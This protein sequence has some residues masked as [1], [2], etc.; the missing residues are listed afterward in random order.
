[1]HRLPTWL[2]GIPIDTLDFDSTLQRIVEW[3]ARDGPPRYVATS[4]VDFLV[5][6][7]AWTS[8]S[9][10]HPELLTIL[11]EAALNTAD[12]MPLVWASR[13]L[14]GRVSERVSGSDLVPALGE[15]AAG[16]QLPLFLLG[17]R[18]EA[19]REAAERLQTRSPGLLIAG[20]ASPFVHVEGKAL[21]HEEKTDRELCESINQSGARILLVGFGNP[22]QEVWFRRNAE[23]LKVPVV[24]GVGGTFNFLAGHVARAPAWMQRS[25]VEWLHRLWSEPR[26]LW[27]RYA[28]GLTKLAVILAPAI[29]AHTLLRWGTEVRSGLDPVPILHRG[30][31]TLRIIR[32]PPAL[33]DATA[34]EL[35]DLGRTDPDQPLL[36]DLA[37]CRF[38]DAHGLGVLWTIHTASAGNDRPLWFLEP[39]RRFRLLLQTHRAWATFAPR[40]CASLE[41]AV[42]RVNERLRGKGLFVAVEG[43]RE[44]VVL[45]LFG[46]M[47]TEETARLDKPALLQA[48]A[49]H[50]TMLDL[51]YCTHIDNDGLAFLLQLREATRE[52]GRTFQ[53]LHPRRRVIDAIRVAGLASLLLSD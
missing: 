38:I 15:A 33:T 5:K 23:R 48:I 18:I 3:A 13:L 31:D 21:A 19:A 37:D 35:L 46:A 10:R 50:H 8:G 24:I 6:A 9:P 26:R 7:L 28:V 14:G 27:R 52:N 42:F 4:N 16:Q 30:L 39:S 51:R 43:R 1:M 34:D 12:G 53:L 22:K 47:H 11:C 20:V 44:T 29:T 25:G 2:V 45:R 41:V 49:G 32:L 36:F 40:L 17:G